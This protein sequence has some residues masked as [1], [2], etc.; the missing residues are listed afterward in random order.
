M[1]RCPAC[2]AAKKQ[3]LATQRPPLH[4][5]EARTVVCARCGRSEVYEGEVPPFELVCGGCARVMHR[6]MREWKRR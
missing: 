2:R 3:D 5:A 6:P 1:R 4:S